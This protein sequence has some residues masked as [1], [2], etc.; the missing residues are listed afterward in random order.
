MMYCYNNVNLLQA[1]IQSG[2]HALV[3][4]FD[5]LSEDDLL[6]VDYTYDNV[7]TPDILDYKAWMEKT[8]YL[9]TEFDKIKVILRILISK[10]FLSIRKLILSTD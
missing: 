10:N 8:L 4:V 1:C 9:E 7:Y 3:R 5:S 2:D 6:M